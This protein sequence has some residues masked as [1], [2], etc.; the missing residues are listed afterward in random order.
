MKFVHVYYYIGSWT[1]LPR[2]RRGL[3]ANAIRRSRH[4][5]ELWELSKVGAQSE[6]TAYIEANVYTKWEYDKRGRGILISS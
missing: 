3:A 2:D 6:Q 4:C 1:V 5:S